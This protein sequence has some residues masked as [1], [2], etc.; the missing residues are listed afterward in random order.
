MARAQRRS[1]EE[2][3]AE[4]RARLIEATLD[5]LMEAGYERTTTVR[6][7]SAAGVSRGAL[8][9][10]FESKEDIVAAA[11]ERL[12]EEHTADIRRLASEVR[13]GTMTLDAL[14]DDLWARFSGRLF[15]VTLEHVSE[16]RHNAAL[17]AKLVPVVRRF[18]AA[19]DETWRGFFADTGLDE[20]QVATILNLTLCL[21]RGMGL[22]SVLR[23]DEPYYQSLLQTW[24][25]LLKMM[26]R[27]NASAGPA[28]PDLVAAP[29]RKAN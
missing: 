27:G 25:N 10:H 11:L 26:M 18:H 20:E 7:V 17:R 2:R 16:A 8:L 9:H 13:A 5:C 28:L 24:K 29:R 22:Q 4:M 19:L 14:L 15:F 3:S 23:Q 1:Q 21:L 6:I 12:L